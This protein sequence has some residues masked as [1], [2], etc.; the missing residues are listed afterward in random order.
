MN[1]NE[2]QDKVIYDIQ[3]DMKSKVSWVVFYA[4]ILLVIGL[5]YFLINNQGIAA[6]KNE[7]DHKEFTQSKIDIAKMQSDIEWIRS[8]M[9]TNGIFPKKDSKI[10]Q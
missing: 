2:K 8:A 5:L 9:E 7:Q 6:A 1:E 3:S 10:K 4:F